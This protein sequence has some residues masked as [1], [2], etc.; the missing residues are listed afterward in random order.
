MAVSEGEVMVEAARKYNRVVQA[1]TWQRSGAHFQKACEIV[2]SGDLGKIAFVRACDLLEHQ[3]AESGIGNPP[4][5]APPP[6]LDWDLWQGPAPAHAFNPNR[7]GVYPDSYSYFRFFWDYAGGQLTDSGIHMLDIVQMAFGDPMPQGVVALGGKYWLQDNSE[8]P[9]TMQASFEY[10]GFLGSW[11]HRSN[12]TELGTNRLMGI[13]FHGSRGTLYVD[14]AVIRVTPEKGSDLRPFEMKRVADPHP[15]HWTNFV[16]CVRTRKRPNS[17]IETCVRSSIT[18]ILGN[19]S[20]R[21][22]TRLDWDASRRTVKQESARSLA[23][24]VI[25]QPMETRSMISRRHLLTASGALAAGLPALGQSAFGQPIGIN[26]YSVRYLAEK[27]LPAT[28]ALIRKLGF[29]NVEA[30]DLYGRSPVEYSKLLKTNGLQAVSIGAS[31]KD[32]GTKLSSV[33]EHA[34]TLGAEYVVCS[35]IPHSAKHLTAQDVPPAAEHLNRWGERLAASGLRLCYHTHGTEFDPSPDGTQFDTLAKLC[36]PRYAN[37]EMDIFWIVY[38]HQ[39]PVDFLRRYPKRF[40]LMHIKDIRKGTPLGGSPADV[41]EDD[42][43]PLGT[44][45]VD[46]R[47]ALIEAKAQ[48]VEYLFLEEEA[49][50]AVPQIRQS[51]RYLAQ[52]R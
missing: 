26:I 13:T 15:L 4:E 39:D 33:A 14:R 37:F 41:R 52:L 31:W 11:E 47:A 22:K 20:L 12:N 9:D 44:G 35:T 36:D 51:L 40:P 28:L 5:Q 18:C 32:L 38:G 50:D 16:D 42:S 17:D 19:L 1:G 27:D 7:F 24:P 29:R 34:K 46:V 3:P 8:T 43:V 49:V 10:P 25:W 30:G 21:A 23:S 45:I 2:K 6:G 48:R